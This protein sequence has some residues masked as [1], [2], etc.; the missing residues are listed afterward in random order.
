VDG[1]IQK[2]TKIKK[3]QNSDAIVQLTGGSDNNGLD[4]NINTMSLF[5]FDDNNY[6]WDI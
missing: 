6:I 3:L 1:T 2:V 5:K 4:M